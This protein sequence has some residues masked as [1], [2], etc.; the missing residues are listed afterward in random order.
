[1]AMGTLRRSLNVSRGRYCHGRSQIRS[2]L[3]SA[4]PYLKRPSQTPECRRYSTRIR[5]AS[6]RQRL[7]PP[8][9]KAM[10]YGSAWTALT[11]PWTVSAFNGSG[12]HMTMRH[13]LKYTRANS[14]GAIPDSVLLHRYAKEL[15]SIS[16][17]SKTGGDRRVHHSSAVWAGGSQR[18]PGISFN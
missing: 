11:V 13:Q 14:R 12:P 2:I 7:S 16:L 8:R 5:A 1:M 17:R 10:A 18:G 9:S 15:E 4:S 3:S 6:S